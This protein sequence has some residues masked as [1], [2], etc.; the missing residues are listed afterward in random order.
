MVCK[1]QARNKYSQPFYSIW[2][3]AMRKIDLL[4]TLLILPLMNCSKEQCT[5]AQDCSE[6]LAIEECNWESN[7]CG[8]QCTTNSFCFGP[9][10]GATAPTC[11]AVS[12]CSLS[13]DCDSCLAID[14]CS[15]SECMM[16]CL[17][18]EKSC[19]TAQDCMTCLTKDECNWT[20]GVCR[21]QCLQGTDCFGPSSSTPSCP[22]ADKC[23]L[24]I[25]NCDS[26]VNIPG[27]HWQDGPANCV[28]ECEGSRTCHGTGPED[29]KCP[30]YAPCSIADNCEDCLDADGPT[31]LS[32]CNWT[33]G[34]CSRS[35]GP[36]SNCIGPDS[37][38]GS[39]CP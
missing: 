23:A 12:L 32:V 30:F 6:C 4:V 5:D 9:S 26:C 18:E 10:L 19:A 22:A 16:L 28:E 2:R 38:N 11:P 15:S 35:C 33:G 20:G 7:K 31:G 29:A 25:N 13:T 21:D 8:E 17:T 37:L 14:G 27:C 24:V 1:T 34:A 36:D 39:F 3:F